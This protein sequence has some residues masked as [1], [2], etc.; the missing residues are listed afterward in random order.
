MNRRVFATPRELQDGEGIV[1]DISIT[2][3]DQFAASEKR[4][5]SN[6]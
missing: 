1:K 2:C 4:S 6:L 3:E 5:Q